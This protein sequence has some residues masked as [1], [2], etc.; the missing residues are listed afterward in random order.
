VMAFYGAH[1]VTIGKVT[2]RTWKMGGALPLARVRPEKKT[3]TL[4]CERLL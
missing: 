4:F 3:G 2:G 1:V